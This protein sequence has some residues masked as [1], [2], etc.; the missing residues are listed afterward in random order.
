MQD[1][2]GGTTVLLLDDNGGQ[3][4]GFAVILDD[5][6]ADP[7]PADGVDGPAITGTYRPME[8]L[9]AFTG[10]DAD[11]T[12]NLLVCDDA[13][14]DVGTV[15]DWSL[16]FVAAPS[17]VPAIFTLSD[18]TN[19]CPA[20]EF[21]IDVDITALGSAAT[22]NILNDGGAAAV[23]GVDGTASPYSVGPFPA[24]TDVVIT[25]EDAADD[26]CNATDNLTTLASCP[27]DCA[28]L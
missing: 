17:C 3:A 16:T 11:G 20:D 26:T 5:D 22:V 2:S 1:P 24:G 8:A 9:S 25:V 4:N 27:P 13:G 6:A 23:N 18:G 14:G 21:F 28:A 15:D 12:W 7:I 19:N 10:V